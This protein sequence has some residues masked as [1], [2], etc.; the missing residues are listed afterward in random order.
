MKR[1]TCFTESLGGGGAE[2]QMVILAGM[3]ADK[4]Y[5]VSLVTYATLPDH[6]STPLGVKRVDIGGTRIK[7][8]KLKAT[9]KLL[10]CF[11]YFL[12]AKTDCIVAYRQCANLRV[13]PPM[14][15]R[16]RKKVRVICSD[17]NT[18]LFVSFKHKIL[19]NYLYKRADY[20]VPNSK[21]ETE[22]IAQHKPQLVPKLQTIHNFTD[23]Q[24]FAVSSMPEKL[25][26]IKV[27]I[28]SRYSSQKNPVGFAKAMKELKRRT[29]QQFEVHWYGAQMGANGGYDNDYLIAKQAVND[30]GIVDVVKLI[31]AVKNPAALMG[32]YHVVCLPSRYEGFSNSVAEGICSGKPMLVSDVSDNSVMVHEG[33]NGFLFDPNDTDSICNAF[34]HF[35]S[36][37]YDEILRMAV[38]SRDIAESLFDKDFFIKQY[39]E[40]IEK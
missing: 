27:A 21:T 1:V 39:M 25:D 22:F 5:D 2:H 17:R 31:P 13:L 29:S 16:S 14:F 30:Y 7:G 40:L 34:L 4:G 36:L 24:Q 37:S 10:K 6:Y 28:F 11:H 19:L 12:W 3:L 23:L 8:R 18:S 15:F 20:I 35:F 38:K 26:I 9:V 32:D 33:E